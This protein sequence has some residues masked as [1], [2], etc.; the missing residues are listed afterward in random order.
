[1]YSL[2]ASNNRLVPFAQGALA[3]AVE[4]LLEH[5]DEYDEIRCEVSV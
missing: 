4:A 3:R 5:D 1:M 2:K